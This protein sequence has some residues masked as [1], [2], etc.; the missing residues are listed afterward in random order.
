MCNQGTVG[1]AKECVKLKEESKLTDDELRKVMA[2]ASTISYGTLAE[3]NHFQAERTKDFKLMMQ[4]YLQSQIKFY[5][6]VSLNVC[7]FLKKKSF[8]SFHGF[9]VKL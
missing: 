2:R 3:M 7:G 1:K 9:D 5:K 4:M 8:P 6:N